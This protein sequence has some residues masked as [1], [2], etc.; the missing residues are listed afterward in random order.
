MSI[1][2]TPYQYARIMTFLNDNQ[3]S[4]PV[5]T[6]LHTQPL[7][8][9]ALPCTAWPLPCITFDKLAERRACEAVIDQ[10]VVRVRPRGVDEVHE[11]RQPLGLLVHGHVR[12]EASN[13]KVRMPA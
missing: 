4:I 7:Q 2:L 9:L 6:T 10:Q 1:F 8:P 12:V 13:G 5:I 3:A 11:G